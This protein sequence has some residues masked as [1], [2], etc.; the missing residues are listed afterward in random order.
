[1]TPPPEKG[2][3][4]EIQYTKSRTPKPRRI[5]DHDGAMITLPNNLLLISF[6]AKV[7]GIKNELMGHFMKLGKETVSVDYVYE[8]FS[9]PAVHFSFP[10]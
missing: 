1:M 10:P 7:K 8:L 9:Y 2:Q 6:G 3:G 5:G 4:F